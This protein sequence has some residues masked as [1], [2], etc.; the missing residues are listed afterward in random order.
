MIVDQH[1]RVPEVLLISKLTWDKLSE[2]DRKLIKQAALD[3][4]KTQREEWTKFEKD[5]EAK[6]KAAGV[7]I[8]QVTDLKPWKEAV[9]PMIDKYRNEYK[10][11][12]DAIEK[13][14]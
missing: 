7:N 13:T 8:V 14:K 4:V 1:Q 2:A 10:E 12:L 11:V 9:K 3:S 6:V 5:A